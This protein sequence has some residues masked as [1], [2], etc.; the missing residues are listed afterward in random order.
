MSARMH[1][2]REGGPLLACAA[3]EEFVPLASVR[4]VAVR[5]VFVCPL[6]GHQEE[7]GP[8]RRVASSA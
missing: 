4:L 3:C 5:R 2:P 7:V 6:C 8:N 1:P